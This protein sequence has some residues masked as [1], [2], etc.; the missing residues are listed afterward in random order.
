MI[1]LLCVFLTTSLI[2]NILLYKVA[3]RQLIRVEQYEDA[4]AEYYTR[5]SV[6]LHTIRYLDEKQMFESDDEVGSVFQ[7]I[8]ETINELRPLVYGVDESAPSEEK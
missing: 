7:Q 2:G 3:N 6:I 4:I 8:V 1:L 5:T